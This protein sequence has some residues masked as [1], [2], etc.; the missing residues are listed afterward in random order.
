MR[1]R[2]GFSLSQ[3][4]RNGMRLLECIQLRAL[5]LKHIQY[6]QQR[7]K[8]W[9]SSQ[10]NLDL[11]IETERMKLTELQGNVLAEQGR[12]GEVRRAKVHLVNCLTNGEREC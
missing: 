1:C 10:F 3:R 8:Q 9:K 7:V 6:S 5:H 11:K 12:A 2:K 4:V